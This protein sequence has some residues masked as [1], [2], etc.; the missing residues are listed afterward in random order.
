MAYVIAARTNAPPVW[1]QA[2]VYEVS[3]TGTGISSAGISHFAA[4]SECLQVLKSM[5]N[6]WTWPTGHQKVSM[7]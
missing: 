2:I 5:V 4:R 3:S 6:K 1:T 7:I